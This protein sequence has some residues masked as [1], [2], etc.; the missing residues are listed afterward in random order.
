MCHIM[1]HTMCRICVALCVTLCEL[2]FVV[3]LSLSL[4]N[5]KNVAAVFSRI[6]YT[7]NIQKNHVVTLSHALGA[8]LQ[9]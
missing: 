5:L 8:K 3:S 2:K 7:R 6:M 9:M 1:C 4:A